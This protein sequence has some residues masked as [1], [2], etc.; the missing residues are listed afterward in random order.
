[1]RNTAR[2]GTGHDR[3][4][5]AVTIAGIR[6][7]QEGGIV[8]RMSPPLSSLPP[9]ASV[10]AGAKLEAIYDLSFTYGQQ[11]GREL[12]ALGVN[13]NFAPLA[14]LS[15]T[16]QRQR[17][18]FRSLIGQRA[19]DASPARVSA[20]VIG[21]GQGLQAQGVLATLKHF[22]GLGRVKEDTHLFQAKLNTSANE[23]A[24]T[25]WV[26]F[27]EGLR[28]TQSLL[29]VGHATLTTVDATRPASLSAKVV[30]GIVRE[31]WGHQ[32]VIVTDDLFMG[33]VVQHGM[34]A[35][36]VD[37]INAGVDLL[38]VS[39]DTDQYYEVMHCL[40]R[41]HQDGRLL[42]QR[43][44]DSDRRLRNLTGTLAPS[45][46]SPSPVAVLRTPRQAR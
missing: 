38:L 45:P 41:A 2:C 5:S 39:Y 42:A 23:L 7:D 24:S 36:G 13:V 31:Q 3:P 43:L 9:L 46:P 11:Q 22:P 34:C 32:G 25:D 35:A 29:M 18:D 20:A 14:D 26:P 44:G 6:T 40:V 17:L 4:E 8:Q 37:A 21:Y 19:I 10:I 16:A 27:R 1:M 12:A 33:P 15:T 28:A 30:Q